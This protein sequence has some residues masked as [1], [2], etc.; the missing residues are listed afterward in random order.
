VIPLTDIGTFKYYVASVYM[1]EIDNTVLCDPSSDTI[2]V[3]FPA[4]GMSEIG[5]GMISI[6]PNPA[7]EVL[8]VKSDYTIT[9]IE[10]MN[11]TGQTVYNSSDVDS[12]TAKLN[13]ATYTPGVYFVKVTTSEGTRTVKI[14]VTH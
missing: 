8:N 14:T 2:T 10:V 4:V 3:L 6:Y 12:K 9:S 11:F 7:T 5:K 13:V 1:N